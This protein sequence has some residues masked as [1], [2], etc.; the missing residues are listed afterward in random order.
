MSVSNVGCIPV[1]VETSCFRRGSMGK[2]VNGMLACLSRYVVSR[3]VDGSAV[4][5]YGVPQK[6]RCR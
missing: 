6:E 2:L 4:G 5:I 1:G 3:N